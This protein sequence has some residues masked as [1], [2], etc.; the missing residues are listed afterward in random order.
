MQRVFLALSVMLNARLVDAFL[1]RV[2]ESVS[3]T[4]K[5]DNNFH[6]Y[7][8]LHICAAEY[9]C[10]NMLHELID[11]CTMYVYVCIVYAYAYHIADTSCTYDII[12]IYI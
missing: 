5:V 3:M 2:S 8:A 9:V 6:V 7:T 12:H 1:P 4:V 10:V 11:I